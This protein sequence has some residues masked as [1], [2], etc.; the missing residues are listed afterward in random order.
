MGCDASVIDVKVCE[1][2]CNKRCNFSRESVAKG[3][4]TF[5]VDGFD[6]L[7]DEGSL[8]KKSL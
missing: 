8:K 7:L 1:D 4:G 6:D 5:F 3:G 2:G